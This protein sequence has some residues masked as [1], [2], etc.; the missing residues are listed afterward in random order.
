MGRGPHNYLENSR[1]SPGANV[2]SEGFGAEQTTFK[3][4]TSSVPVEVVPRPVHCA[5]VWC[6]GEGVARK[7]VRNDLVKDSEVLCSLLD[8]EVSC[9]SFEVHL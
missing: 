5:N 7:E 1:A 6:R 8:S 9:S 2:H 3:L 4:W